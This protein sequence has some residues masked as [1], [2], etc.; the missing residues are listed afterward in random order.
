MTWKTWLWIVAA[1]VVALW[2]VGCGRHN[3]GMGS[4]WRGVKHCETDRQC[5]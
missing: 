2:L 5:G 4:L 1:V 3:D